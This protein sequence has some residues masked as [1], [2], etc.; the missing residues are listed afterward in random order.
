MN[1]EK[2]QMSNSVAILGATGVVG[3]KAIALLSRNPRFNILELVASDQR[4]GQAFG[5]VCDWREPLA[6]MPEAVAAMKLSSPQSLRAEFIVSCLPSDVAAELE[7]MLAAQGK[8]VCSNASTFRMDPKV[9]LLVPE[10]N[11]DHLALLDKQASSGKIITNPNCSAVGITLALAPLMKLAEIEQVS[12][13]T[14]QSV[15]GAGYPGVPSLDILGNTIPH[16][17]GE[18]D[19]ITE[20]T[21]RILGTAEA[22]ASFAVATHVHRVPV[23]FGH[24]VTLHLTFK[25]K[26]QPNQ[27]IEAY[28]SWNKKHPGLF[29]LHDKDGR[30]QTTKD[31]S[32][33]DMRVHLGHLRQGDRPN[34]LG[35]VSLTHN[36]VRGAAG[37]VIANMESYLQRPS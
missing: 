23:L 26:V 3:Q 34:M 10:I 1:I 16:I 15:S 8:V 18:A 36:L 14:L 28:Q 22:P 2:K 4:V 31:L 17:A 37:A 24:T 19:K 5:E 6:P 7:P 33:D 32:H 25:E 9:P 27:A 12:I 30:P 21:K 35:L 11:A 13:V 20:E 29:V